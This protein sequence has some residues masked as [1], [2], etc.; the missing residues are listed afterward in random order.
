[1]SKAC[2]YLG[3][4]RASYYRWKT[5][6]I[7]KVSKKRPSP[8]NSLSSKER[9][10]V[11]KILCSE[12]FTDKSPNSIWAILLDEEDTYLCSVRTMYRVLHE[13]MV[14][15]DRR[16]QARKKNYERPELLAT[17][18]NQVWSWDITKLKGPHKGIFL[19]LYVVIDIFSRYIVAWLLAS[20]ESTDF[21]RQLIQQA[22]DQQGIQ[23]GQLTLHADLGPSMTSKGLAELLLR[24]DIGKSHN[25][26]YT[27]NDNP[28]SESQF[29]TMKYHPTFPERFGSSEDGI[30]FCR[31]FFGWYNHDH[32]HS[33]ICLLTPHAVHYG[34]ADNLLQKRFELM[35]AFFDKHPKRFSNGCPKREELP[36]KVWINKPFQPPITAEEF[37]SETVNTQ[38]E[39]AAEHLS[40]HDNDNYLCRF[41]TF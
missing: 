11:L 16:I 9:Q 38:R 4:S 21:A 29:K 15:L 1:M 37:L 26:P 3:A 22:V 23:P 6:E 39:V 19:H 14:V 25:R 35:K 17:G 34:L 28:Y 5:P 2:E 12:R 7:E 36:D 40:L 32:R 33:G 27:S 24:L 18:P 13:N 20:Y 31:S 8:E 10:K 41:A 30:V